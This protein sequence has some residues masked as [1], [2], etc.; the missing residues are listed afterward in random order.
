[1]SCKRFLRTTDHDVCFGNFAM[2]FIV[3]GVILTLAAFVYP[4]P[5]ESELDPSQT[6]KENESDRIDDANTRFTIYIIS[7]IGMTMVVGGGLISS[8]LLTKYILLD[9][10]VKTEENAP[11]FIAP[12]NNQ[13]FN[14]GIHSQ[15][16]TALP[17]TPGTFTSSPKEIKKGELL[18]NDFCEAGLAG[19]DIRQYGSIQ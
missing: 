6:A 16:D 11:D 8:F 4:L 10:C 2:G 17:V 14:G 7:L 1:M 18:D 13:A 5:L 15:G 3:C 19:S 9:E 12:T